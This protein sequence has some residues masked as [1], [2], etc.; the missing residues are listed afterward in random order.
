MSDI[1]RIRRFVARPVM[2]PMNMPLQTSSGAVATAPLVLIDCETEQ[3]VR[4]YSYVFAL[5]PAAL[6]SLTEMVKA[7]SEF[8][9]GDELVPFEI[10]RKLTHKF[11]LLGLAGVQR[12]AQA[13]IDMAAWDTLARARNLTREIPSPRLKRASVKIRIAAA[14]LRDPRGCTIL[15]RDPG[16][17]DDVLF[18]RM[19]QF[20][21]VEV[22]RHA[23]AELAAHLHHILKIDRASLSFESLPAARH[24]V[25]F[26]NITLLPFLARVTRLPKRPRTRVL[27]LNR[28]ARLPVSSATRKIA[29]AVASAPLTR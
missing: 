29:A 24:G 28:L 7:M 3:G 26:R 27:P 15:V 18:S 11:T 22:A 6:K 12:L 21:A 10:E 25:T 17:H 23:E 19:W 2:A 16:A 13:G 1:I 5:T 14:I 20:P 8:L 4:G 9:V